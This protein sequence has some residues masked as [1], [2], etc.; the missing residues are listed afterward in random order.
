ML[1]SFC[2]KKAA[3]QKNNKKPSI[4]IFLK[5]MSCECITEWC[6]SKGGRKECWEMKCRV[7]SKY[8]VQKAASDLP[9]LQCIIG[10]KLVTDALRSPNNVSVSLSLQNIFWESPS[11]AISSVLWYFSLG[12]SVPCLTVPSYIYPLSHFPSYHHSFNSGRFI[13][14]SQCKHVIVS[15]NLYY[16]YQYEWWF[17]FLH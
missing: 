9:F 11:P 13:F 6:Q 8:Q 2:E 17:S 15:E 12:P 7:S 4:F 14:P 1:G 3:Q 16:P 10:R 5:M